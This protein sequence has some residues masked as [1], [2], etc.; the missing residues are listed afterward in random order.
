MRLTLL[1]LEVMNTVN[2]FILA[3]AI[4]IMT[5]E[6]S[7]QLLEQP[8]NRLKGR[9]ELPVGVVHAP[10]KKPQLRQPVPCTLND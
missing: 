1:P 4:S 8:L 7:W 2:H 10:G 3:V 9:S 5:A 6:V